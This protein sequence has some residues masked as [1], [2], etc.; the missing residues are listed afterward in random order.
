MDLGDCVLITALSVSSDA[1]SCLVKTLPEITLSV[2]IDMLSLVGFPCPTLLSLQPKI[3]IK[4]SITNVLSIILFIV[5]KYFDHFIA[6]FFLYK[7]RRY[8][9][10]IIQALYST[11]I[12]L[13]QYQMEAM[14][15][16]HHCHY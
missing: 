6:L 12:L 9:Y 15:F 11:P 3:N 13:D 4:E 10:D 16:H 5:F 2:S 14:E 1:I 7:I 8:Y